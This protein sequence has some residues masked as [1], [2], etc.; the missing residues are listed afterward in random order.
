MKFDGVVELNESLF[1]GKKC[2]YH[3][4]KDMLCLIA[5]EF[6]KPLKKREDGER[7]RSRK[8]DNL[9]YP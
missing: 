2:K 1:G 6:Q 9:L 3:K 8:G 5:Y 7:E 4:G